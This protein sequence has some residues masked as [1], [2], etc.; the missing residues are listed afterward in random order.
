VISLQLPYPVS[1]NVYWRH[2][3]VGRR[4]VTLVSREAKAYRALV[5]AL[6]ADVKAIAGELHVELV[7]HPRRTAKGVASKVRI[8]LDNAV[9]VALDAL[10]GLAFA[11][12]AQVVE[13]HAMVGEPMDGGGLG[14]VVTTRDEYLEGLF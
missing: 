8:D 2:V 6:C 5:A 14:V 13:L 1:A 3:V 4:A 12:D 10:Q 7:L 9:K 11:D